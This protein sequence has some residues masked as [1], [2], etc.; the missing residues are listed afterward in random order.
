MVNFNRQFLSFKKLNITFDLIKQFGVLR[1]I[2][3]L[4]LGRVIMY[5]NLYFQEKVEQEIVESGA[6]TISTLSGRNATAQNDETFLNL[7]YRQNFILFSGV[8]IIL[9]LLNILIPHPFFMTRYRLGMNFRAALTR[10]VYE[11]ALR[12]SN[13]GVQRFTVGKI[14]NLI[15]NDV[16]RF[17]VV[18]VN[19]DFSYL[20]IPYT[21]IAMGILYWYF[22]RAS[23]GALA[24]ALVYIPCK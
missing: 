2:I 8:L 9:A 10:L 14:V 7:T 6:L 11:K 13:S 22:G 16:N 20:A 3:P 4:V 24:I 23:L 18:F 17:E 21:A 12:V 19:F 15:S 1:N 5:S